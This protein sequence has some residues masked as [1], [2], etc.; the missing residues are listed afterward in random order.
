MLTP[1]LTQMPKLTD[2]ECMERIREH[3]RR[4]GDSL[5][6]PVHNYQRSEIVELADEVGD[7]LELARR[8]TI[9]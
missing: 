6:L 3:K 1:L 7:S 8:P 5:F 4:L 2:A 9:Q